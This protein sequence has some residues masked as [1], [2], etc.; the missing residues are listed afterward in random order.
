MM[1]GMM[2]MPN[3]TEPRQTEL[4]GAGAELQPDADWRPVEEPPPAPRD[5]VSEASAPAAAAEA[6]ATAAEPPAEQEAPAATAAGGDKRQYWRSI[7]TGNP[8]TVPSAVR[9]QA[10]VDDWDIPEQQREY[11]LLATINR[12]WAADHLP[13]SREQVQA[14]WPRQ[15]E[16]LAKRLQVRNNEREVFLALSQEAQ[17]EPRREAAERITNASYLAGLE[18]K[19]TG[20]WEAELAGLTAEDAERARALAEATYDYG[21]SKR[22]QYSHLAERIAHGVD[23]FA[24][25]EESPF[26]APR[27]LSALPDLLQAVDELAD[28][29][30]DDR[31]TAL[32]LASGM[33][34][35]HAAAADAEAPGLLSRVVQA[36][37]RGSSH[38]QQAL[39][40]GASGAGIA[41]LSNMGR[42]LES[43][44]ISKSAQAWDKR[45]QMLERVRRLSQEELRPLVLP[46][47]KEG[48]ASYLITAS[49]QVPAA[50]LSCCGG[51]GFSA[52][53]LGAVGDSVAQA[54]ER[55]PLADRE[56]QLY[57]GLLAGAIQ[58][59]IYM[60]LNRVGGRLLEQS[61]SAVRRADGVAGYT[62]AGLNTMGA[63]TTE[64]AK[65]LAAGKLV[66]AADLGAQELAARLS[67]TASNIDWQTFGDNLTD[68]EVNMHEAAGLLPFL[69]IGSGRLGLQHFRSPRAILGEG[70][71][72]EHLGVPE[73]QVLSILREQQPEQRSEMLQD[74]LLHSKLFSGMSEFPGAKRALNLLQTDENNRIFDTEVVHDFLK[75]PAADPL[76]AVQANKAKAGEEAAGFSG[77]MQVEALKVW[78]EWRE[79]SPLGSSDNGR[80]IAQAPSAEMQRI[81]LAQED[82]RWG[83]ET[84][85]YLPLPERQSRIDAC[86]EDLVRHS[87]LFL[88]NMFSVD[89]VQGI[90][91]GVK[92]WARRAEG[93]RKDLLTEVVK[94]V[95][96][97]CEGMPR[98][99]AMEKLD[100][101]MSDFTTTYKRDKYHLTP[102]K[103]EQN[104]Y[105]S[106]IIN[107]R[108]ASGAKYWS[109]FPAAMDALSV[110]R[111]MH[112]GVHMLAELAPQMPDFQTSLTRGVA[113]AQAVSTY[114]LRILGITPP[115]PNMDGTRFTR[116]ITPMKEYTQQNVARYEAYRKLTGCE[117]EQTL[118]ADGRTYM[119]GRRVDGTLTHWHETPEQVINDI[120]GNAALEYTDMGK[121]VY[122]PDMISLARRKFN[123]MDLPPVNRREKAFTKADQTCRMALS[124]LG[125]LW[126]GTATSM[127]PGLSIR[128]HV[129]AAKP[130][131]EP[132]YASLSGRGETFQA[133]H[134]F[135][136]TPV[137]LAQIRFETGIRRQIMSGYIKPLDL[138]SCLV[139]R[140]Y[141]EPKQL[142][143]M[144]RLVS[145]D[146]D[147]TNTERVYSP[148][149]K[150]DRRAAQALDEVVQSATS[151]ALD[152]FMGMQSRLK[153]PGRVAT[154]LAT[155][156]FH[157]AAGDE[158]W[159]RVIGDPTDEKVARWANTAAAGFLHG[160][161]DKI[162][163]VRTAE[164]AESRTDILSEL[165]D[166]V[167]NRKGKRN[168]EQGWCHHVYGTHGGLSVFSAPQY[169]WN[170]L[171]S[172][173]RAW[174][175][176]P[177][178]HSEPMRR[179]IEKFCSQVEYFTGHAGDSLVDSSLK[180]L[181]DML[182]KYPEMHSYSFS[183]VD[184]TH[185]YKM[186]I[187]DE[188]PAEDAGDTSY[189]P[190]PL[191]KRELVRRDYELERAE[192]DPEFIAKEPGGRSCMLL[193][194]HL[195]K[196]Q[197]SRPMADASGIWWRDT[198]YGQNG[199]APTGLGEAYAPVHPI[200]PLLEKLREAGAQVAAGQPLRVCGT[201]LTGVDPE[202]KVRPISSV[203]TYRI[204]GDDTRV[205]RLMPGDPM[206][207]GT[208]LRMPY[209]VQCERGAYI[210]NR[211]IVRGEDGL[212]AACIP[213]QLFSPSDMRIT[214]ESHGY[215]WARS[216]YESTL[217]GIMGLAWDSASSI[218]HRSAYLLE[219]LLRLAED[220]GFSQSI[221]HKKLSE[222]GPEEVA[223]LNLIGDLVTCVC[224]ENPAPAMRRMRHMADRYRKGEDIML[225]RMAEHLSSLR[226]P[227]AAAAPRPPRRA[228]KSNR[229]LTPAQ[230][231]EQP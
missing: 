17:D 79:L 94:A 202:L 219:H 53:T 88:M 176:M 19:P 105:I 171:C 95:S 57:A 114:L 110:V 205:Y 142:A 175:S 206:L 193:L 77:E 147:Y 89:S 47:E 217:E 159:R 35:R 220:S 41:L 168:Y 164:Q 182:R 135:T 156:A 226:Y 188:V 86:A 68:I 197:G 51:A 183:G 30:E 143:D 5:E 63:M 132:L 115:E 178:K 200:L 64:A 150:E 184:E 118:A 91:Q 33:V 218:G 16:R 69:L 113:P 58:A 163:Q 31:N 126:H 204:A 139:E 81:T 26:P 21:R 99:L 90:Y 160:R 67:R 55:A 148:R 186:R 165:V 39:L 24:A 172:P 87:Y 3:D 170:M 167:F 98:E 173:W 124:E 119:R 191:Y 134:L 201:E 76:K 131:A 28:L 155:Q 34:R 49:E 149:R 104:N 84:P 65:L 8:A 54:R 15:R 29:E 66:G 6:P 166:D 109:K 214:L 228:R 48:V 59:G 74:A 12:S 107:R 44:G 169:Y 133:S 140:G 129:R 154:W 71:M 73:E 158:L 199:Q 181:D 230:P 14:D 70:R 32:Y 222:C 117:L 227:S 203:T 190:Q 136:G 137:A 194:D 10:G 185:L 40:Q 2:T 145:A 25:Y 96:A 209:V 82:S 224:A 36:M 212:D 210:G 151:Y 211:G 72:L 1:D 229:R 146:Y 108:E 187:S 46:G 225:H 45:M 121:P 208:P 221:A 215:R 18:D 56:L 43:E 122:S 80:R 42:L 112:R 195:R 101:F 92:R 85:A 144:R 38:M 111:T 130:G 93:A 83:R 179:Y 152:Y 207:D 189:R 128:E 62:I 100:R 75:L 123:L 216:G 27:V 120:A 138:M 174:Q 11:R 13:R 61:I 157:P 192:N 97:I 60:N 223:L 78:N 106:R 22:E 161:L 125:E 9:K 103:S 177:P 116:N 198:L 20:S 213:L 4:G 196:Y 50:L 52:L 7:L 162:E 153:Y 127:Q 180:M 102:T 141:A 23:A 37:R 231:T